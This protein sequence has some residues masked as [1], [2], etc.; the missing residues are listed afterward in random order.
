MGQRRRD[1]HQVSEAV[2][3]ARDDE[4]RRELG[5]PAIVD[6]WEHA[7][8]PLDSPGLGGRLGEN[9]S[10]SDRQLGES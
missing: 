7:I 5:E 2:G 8:D 10:I 3:S 4:S 1:V 9:D 6:G